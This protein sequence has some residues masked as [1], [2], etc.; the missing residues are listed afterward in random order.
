MSLFMF[1]R[2][3]TGAIRRPKVPMSMCKNSWRIQTILSTI[4]GRYYAM[5]R[6]KRWDRI[7]KAYQSIVFGQGPRTQDPLVLLK[8]EYTYDT[9]DEFILPHTVGDYAGIKDGDGLFMVNFRADRVR[10][11]LSALLM[12]DFTAFNRGRPVSFGAT[13]AMGEYSTSSPL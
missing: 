3:L 10:Q 13:L 6:D 7:E 2:S 8:D 9:G 5:D 12:P 1:M 11:I 4:G